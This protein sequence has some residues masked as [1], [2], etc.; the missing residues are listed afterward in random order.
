MVK[1]LMTR[2]STAAN[3]PRATARS[4]VLC[5]S[6]CVLAAGACSR[7]RSHYAEAPTPQSAP[8]S[9]AVSATRPGATGPGDTARTD[10]PVPLA[11]MPA[12]RDD[13]AAPVVDVGVTAA[14]LAPS[15]TCFAVDSDAVGV[16]PHEVG[17][18]NVVA[19]EHQCRADLHPPAQDEG[20]DGIPGTTPDHMEFARAIGAALLPHWHHESHHVG[21]GSVDLRFQGCFGVDVAPES[22]APGTTHAWVTSF[23]SD[24]NRQLFALAPDTP[25][26]MRR[27]WE[28]SIGPKMGTSAPTPSSH[29]DVRIGI[30]N[31]RCTRSRATGSTPSPGEAS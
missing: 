14:A 4:I 3:A 20:D 5:F 23:T 18:R 2:V 24:T 6:A 22:V 17:A 7:V 13:V 11:V 28:C 25:R 10:V 1:T 26:A 27:S 19:T 21:D 16:S 8:Y 12:A 29:I 31:A 9:Q 30:L 15:D